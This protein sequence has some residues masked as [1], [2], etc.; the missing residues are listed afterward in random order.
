MLYPGLLTLDSV[1]IWDWI[2]FSPGALVTVGCFTASRA[3]IY[4]ILV[5]TYLPLC[6]RLWQSKM[7]TD[8]ANAVSGV[9]LSVIN[10]LPEENNSFMALKGKDQK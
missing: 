5:E 4:Y 7:T 6:R 10:S 9:G 8:F 2:I 3:S 1:D